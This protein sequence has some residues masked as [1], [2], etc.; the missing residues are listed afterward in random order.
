MK[1]IEVKL[2]L[3]VVAPLLDVIKQLTGGLGQKLAAPQELGDIE[4]EFRDAWVGELLQSQ[5]A[6][7][8]VLLALFD[9]E[10]FSEGV[11]AFDEENAE[12]IV[13]ACAAVR[14]RLREI[15]LKDRWFG[16]TIPES[17]HVLNAM[18]RAAPDSYDTFRG[19]YAGVTSDVR[20]LAERFTDFMTQRTGVT[21]AKIRD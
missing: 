14:L 19:K 12:P 9:E 4:S 10:F 5:T 13:R 16:P 18:D 3:P 11:V 20:R 1:R 6:D 7:V 17:V 21:W 2:S 15:Y 8:A